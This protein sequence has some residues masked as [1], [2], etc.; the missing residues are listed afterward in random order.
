MNIF[1]KLKNEQSFT[2]SEKGIVNY[3]LTQPEEFLSASLETI[4]Q[5]CFVSS[6]TVYR[7]CTKLGCNG[8][9]DLKVQISGSLPDY[10]AENQAFDFNYPVDAKQSDLEAVKRLEEDYSQTLTAVRNLL[11]LKTVRQVVR[12]MQKA[13]QI[14]IYTSAGN[15]YFA[16]NFRF[17]MQEIGILVN[18]PVDEY[19]QRLTAAASDENHLGIIISF[20][21]RGA[22]M[23]DVTSILKQ[24]K[25]PIVLISSVQEK[26]LSKLADWHL[27]MADQ[28]SHYNKMSSFSTRLSLLYILDVLYLFYFRLDYDGNV[29][30]KLDYY[31]NLI[32]PRVSVDTLKALEEKEH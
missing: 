4:C 3:I 11:D 22:V 24:K 12:V 26:I 19:L 17:Q 29:Q 21:G 14:D 9:T 32:R 23:S 16:Q 15:V 31:H 28:E 27:Y 7:L 2:K 25:T 30:K 18:V 8:L 10:M 13:K 1:T 20:G 5:S 6:P